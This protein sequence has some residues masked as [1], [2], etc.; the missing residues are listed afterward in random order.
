MSR[1][2]GS[3][4]YL[5][6]TPYENAG[7]FLD[8]LVANF[9]L[10]ILFSFS[11]HRLNSQNQSNYI[12]LY[13]N[14]KIISQYK[15]FELPTPEGLLFLTL[16]L[17]VVLIGV[18]TLWHILR[19]KSW[20]GKFDYYLTVNA[21]TAWLGN[22]LRTFRIVDRT[23]FWVWDYYPPGYPDWK[24]RLARA[25]YWQFDKW[26]STQSSATIFLNQRLYSLRQQIGVLADGRTYPVVSIGTNPGKIKLNEQLIIGHLGVLKQ[27]QGLDF[28]IDCLPELLKLYPELVIE[29]VGS[30]PDE[31]HFKL[32]AKTYKCFKFYGFI[33]DENKVDAIIQNWTIGIATYQPDKSSPA[34][35]TD[36]SK[37]KAYLSQ[38]VPVITTPI[39][40]MANEIEQSNSGLVVQY[41]KNDQ[42]ISAIKK[43]Y[44]NQKKYKL[45]AL[46]LAKRY[47][48]HLLYEK[49]IMPIDNH[50][51]N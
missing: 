34:Y 47:D 39:A 27:S 6:F 11:F 36:P 19:F 50:Q 21:F 7:R 49:L 16:P 4:V 35:W 22:L 46:E 15:L 20:Y 26:S 24:I 41:N 17:I 29:I 43:I 8:W 37:I 18:Q 5:N 40:T 25:A 2:Y 30:G 14:G 13:Q 9:Q 44:H 48:Y 10:V 1:K 42:L 31:A 38:A 33:K 12:R 23:I 51:K 32:R 3:I 45:A 28:L